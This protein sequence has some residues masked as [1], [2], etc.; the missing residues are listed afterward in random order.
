M[1]HLQTECI[2]KLQIVLTRAFLFSLDLAILIM[3]D[4]DLAIL[5]MYYLQSHKTLT[6]VLI[7]DRYHLQHFIR[8]RALVLCVTDKLLRFE[9]KNNNAA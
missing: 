3:Y 4:L 7:Y 9:M 5:V 6:F 2:F 8:L 1:I